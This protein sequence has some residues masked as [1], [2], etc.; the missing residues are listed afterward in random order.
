MHI[1][2]SALHRPAKPTGVCRHAAN[3]AQCFAEMSTV[4][5]VSLVV[6][7]WQIDYFKSSFNI[8]LEKIKLIGVD[9]ENKAISRNKWFLLEL[10]ELTKL[11]KPD[12]VH[13]SFPIPF[14]RQ[15][16]APPVVATVHD[17]YPFECPNNFGYPN[18]LFNQ[19]FLKQCINSVD[20]ISCVSQSTLEKLKFY[21]P[22]AYSHKKTAVIYNYVDF[23]HAHPQAPTSLKIQ[24]PFLLCVA[25][26]RKNKNLNLLIDSYALL[27]KQNKLREKT[28]LIIVGDSGPETD[29]I[30]TQ[31]RTLSL[32]NHI[33]LLS[34]INDSELCWLY[35]NCELFIIPSS[36]E[37]FCLPLAEALYLSCK[38]VCSDIPIFREIA[39]NSTYFSLAGNSVNN[40][41]QAI[42]QSLAQP[43]SAE[44]SSEDRFAKSDIANKYLNFYSKLV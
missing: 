42:T 33:V 15:L 44:K 19:L 30:H 21:F 16:F 17:L 3:L 26:H 43:Q 27:L 18:V 31:I 38:V 9:I 7:A 23:S 12:I 1:L 24:H 22:R 29:S 40:L 25:Q 35:K 36:T 32:Q 14:F 5:Q 20:G 8:S 11:L 10:P 34:S 28:Q 2:I 4:T 39:T 13:L 37:G 6:G 41:A